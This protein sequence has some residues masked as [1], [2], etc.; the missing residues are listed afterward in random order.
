MTFGL[1][2]ALATLLYI[3]PGIWL[4]RTRVLAHLRSREFAQAAG[5]F[6]HRNPSGRAL[7]DRLS[8]DRRLVALFLLCMFFACLLC[9]PDAY[10]RRRKS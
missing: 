5:R 3:L 8:N 2:L 6:L 1:V 4:Y 9:W 7:Q 10:L